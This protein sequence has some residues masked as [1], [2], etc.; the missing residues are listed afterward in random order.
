M[1]GEAFVG[2]EAKFYYNSGTY[3]SPTWAL[4]DNCQDLDVADARTA[5]AAPIRGNWP[6][7]GHLVGMRDI[8]ITWSSLQKQETTDTVLTAL[9]AAY[10]AG[11][12]TEFAIADQAIATVGCKYQRVICVITKADRSEPIDGAVTISFEAKPAVN[13]GGNNPSLVTVAS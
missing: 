5:V 10:V 2:G 3:G 7:L 13:N 9:L 8:T 12:I 1:A 6:F 11:T 4:I